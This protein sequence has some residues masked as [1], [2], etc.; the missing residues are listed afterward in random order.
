MSIKTLLRLWTR[1]VDQY[2]SETR[3]IMSRIVKHVN[4]EKPKGDDLEDL[5]ETLGESIFQS[6]LINLYSAQHLESL[7]LKLDKSTAKL[8]TYVA[9]LNDQNENEDSNQENE[10]SSEN[11]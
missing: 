7:D 2:T 10:I 11:E 9:T 5:I 6:I 8:D 1:A 4:D 3:R